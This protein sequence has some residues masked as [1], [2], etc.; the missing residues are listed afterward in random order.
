MQQQTTPSLIRFL[1]GRGLYAILAL[2]LVAVSGIA[3]AVLA[4]RDGGTGEVDRNVS[5]IPDTR[6]TT[7]PIISP[8]NPTRTTTTTRPTT[9]VP[10]TKPTDGIKPPAPLRMLPLSNQ[11]LA[12]FSADAPVYNATLDLWQTHN[13]VDFAGQ[14]AQQVR[15]VCDSTV[16]NV[17]EDVRLGKVVELR[18][19][20]GALSRYA[21]VNPSVKKGQALAC[22]DVIGTLASVPAEAH[23]PAHLHLEIEVNGKFVD[24]I[25]YIGVSVHT[26]NGNT[27]TTTAK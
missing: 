5:D 19:A 7:L 24:P 8:T 14:A 25:E 16:E 3:V 10:T 18:H 26:V 23:L 13:G 17:R 22:G 9:T 11:V 21:G 27:T 4:A 12:S 20:D 6:T 15:A 2:I 1:R